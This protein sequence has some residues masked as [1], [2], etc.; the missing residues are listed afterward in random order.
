[1]KRLF[2]VLLALSMLTGAFSGLC[3]AQSDGSEL[4]GFIADIS[5][6]LTAYAENDA[7]SDELAG[8]VVVACVGDSITKGIGTDGKPL[9][10]YPTVLGDARNKQ[11]K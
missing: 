3:M 6:F 4:S 5:Y 8:K 11:P 1:M 9:R 2:S 7:Q 10:N